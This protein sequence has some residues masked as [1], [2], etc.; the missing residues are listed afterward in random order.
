MAIL[1]RHLKVQFRWL[2]SAFFT[3]AADRSFADLAME[4]ETARILEPGHF[5]ISS[6]FEFQTDPCGKEY[7]LPMAFEIGLYRHLELL[8]EPVPFTSIRPKGGEAATGVGD[9]ETTLTYL[10][11]EEKKYVP[12]VALAGEIK[13]PT[14]ATI[15]IAPNYSAPVTIKY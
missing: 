7:A 14:A 6:A 10:I 15:T 9:L 3:V 8:I 12:A 5:E 13:F 4:T 11:I 1:N 2:L